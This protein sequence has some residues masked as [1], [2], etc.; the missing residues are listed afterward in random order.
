MKLPKEK[1]AADLTTNASV[2]G[3]SASPPPKT[4][5]LPASVTEEQKA[6]FDAALIRDFRPKMPHLRRDEWILIR[7]ALEYLSH[8]K[9]RQPILRAEIREVLKKVPL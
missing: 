4:S 8:C 2:T 5:D 9:P 1:P 7:R 6:A 3:F